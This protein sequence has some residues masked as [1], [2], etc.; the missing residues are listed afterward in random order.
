M[1]WEWRRFVPIYQKSNRLKRIRTVVIG[2]IFM[3]LAQMSVLANHMNQSE[4]WNQMAFHL[5]HE[6]QSFNGNV[7]MDDISFLNFEGVIDVPGD[8]GRLSVFINKENVMTWER[9]LGHEQVSYLNNEGA[10]I[11]TKQSMKAYLEEMV[12]ELGPQSVW[13]NKN[14]IYLENI[15]IPEP[16]MSILMNAN[17]QVADEMDW[18]MRLNSREQLK[19]ATGNIMIS[20]HKITITLFFL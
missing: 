6:S 17:I 9:A 12:Q 4:Q 19:Q 1:N 2:G 16:L 13:S 15:K 10:L 5:Y 20:G 14:E 8:E 7:A 3:V 18:T 11:S